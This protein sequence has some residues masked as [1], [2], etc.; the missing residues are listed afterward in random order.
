M[1]PPLASKAKTNMAPPSREE[2]EVKLIEPA[3]WRKTSLEV[4]AP[5]FLGAWRLG[6]LVV[7]N[8]S[9]DPTTVAME[10]GTGRSLVFIGLPDAGFAYLVVHPT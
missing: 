4:M 6:E 2:Q 5:P 10:H 9:H 7:F 3:S 8:V 1:F